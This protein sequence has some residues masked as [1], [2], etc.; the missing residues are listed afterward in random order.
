LR[1]ASLVVLLVLAGCGGGDPSPQLVDGS[2]PGDPPAELAELDDAVMTRTLVMAA[3]DVDEIR[4]QACG[5]P[6]ADDTTVVERVGLH[7][8]SLTFAGSV[9]SLNG[10]GAIPDQVQDSDRLFP[11]APC[12][13][14]VGFLEQG[15]LNDPRLGLCTNTDGD[16]TGFVWVEPRPGTQ[17]VVVTDAGRRE[18]YEVAESLPVRVTTTDGVRPESSR[19]AFAIEE[20]AADGSLVRDYMLEAAVAG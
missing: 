4:L 10:C 9:S 7:G 6:Q 3:G 16:L 14:S 19:A 8:S 5:A 11:E 15:V 1:A 18:I 12:E 17:W 13:V 2:T 20:Y